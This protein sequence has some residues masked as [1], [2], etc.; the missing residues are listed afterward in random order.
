MT[1]IVHLL[2]SDFAQPLTVTSS[3][4]T[5]LTILT[6]RIASSVL[7]ESA[8]HRRGIASILSA[9]VK[10]ETDLQGNL[11]QMTVLL[12]KLVRKPARTYCWQ[13]KTSL[14]HGKVTGPQLIRKFFAFYG[15]RIIMTLPDP[16]LSEINS[17][18]L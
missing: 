18:N 14:S 16:I 8:E 6:I 4:G 12:D 7:F 11:T 15:T 17:F 5:L 13:H 3:K 1:E 2:C 9:D 10:D